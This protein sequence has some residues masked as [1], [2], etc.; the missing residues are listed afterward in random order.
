MK[1]AL[2]A[3]GG[4]LLGTILAVG[5][6]GTTQD[7]HP[8]TQAPAVNPESP[9]QSL[10]PEQVDEQDGNAGARVGEQDAC[11]FVKC[12]GV[13]WA[14]PY[15]S[16]KYNNCPEYGKYSCTQRH[17]AYETNGWKGC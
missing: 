11:C 8:G 5:C 7:E 9:T 14:G 3:V 6:G 17:L 12:K 16:V 1:R 2:G 10:T 13:D 4:L 15:R